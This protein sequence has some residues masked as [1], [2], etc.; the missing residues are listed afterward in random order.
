MAETLVFALRT[1]DKRA[2]ALLRAE[3]LLNGRSV[4]PN[5]IKTTSAISGLFFCCSELFK[6]SGFFGN[7]DVIKDFPAF[8]F[9]DEEISSISR[10]IGRWEFG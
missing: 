7:V 5:I 10:I 2:E 9:A 6:K 8:D 3:R 1:E 4:N